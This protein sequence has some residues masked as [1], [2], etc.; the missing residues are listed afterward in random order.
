MKN[1]NS[2]INGYAAKT[3]IKNV[4]PVKSCVHIKLSDATYWNIVFDKYNGD[5]WCHYSPEID[6]IITASNFITQLVKTINKDVHD[7]CIVPNP[8]C[9]MW[10]FYLYVCKH[11]ISAEDAIN[12]IAYQYTVLPIVKRLVRDLSKAIYQDSHPNFDLSTKFDKRDLCAVALRML[13]CI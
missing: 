8:T 10:T 9:Y 4:I 6:G 1:R 5:L 11:G 2:I 12:R 3:S 7:G 13:D